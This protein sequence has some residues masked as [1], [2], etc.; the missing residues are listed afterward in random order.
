[1]SSNRMFV[2]LGESHITEQRLIEE[3]MR[4]G[5]K[6]LRTLAAGL[7]ECLFISDW[8]DA[9]KIARR[10]IEAADYMHRLNNRLEDVKDIN[11]SYA[12]IQAHID[13]IEATEKHDVSD[14]S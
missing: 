13:R 6:R 11:K 9:S 1:M 5:V 10:I 8:D 2:A 14:N 12:S 4:D 3:K 7:D